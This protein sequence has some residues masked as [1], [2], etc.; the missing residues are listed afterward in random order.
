MTEQAKR[1]GHLTMSE[2][3]TRIYVFNGDADGLIAQYLLSIHLGKPNLRITGYKRD[4][5]LLK[6]L[7]LLAVSAASQLYVLD[8]SVK[9]N[10][11]YLLPLL[12]QGNV[13]V[14]WFDHHAPGD[15][16]VH[17]NLKLHINQAS[18]TCTAMIVNTFFGNR[19][20]LW[21]AMALFGDNNAETAEAILKNQEVSI[22][23]KSLLKKAGILLN[24]NAYAEK[25]GDALFEPADLAIRMDAFI[26]ESDSKAALKFARDQGI[27]APLET[28]YLQDEIRFQNLQPIQVSE[29]SQA[30]L[31]PNEPWARRFSATWV[32]ALVSAK[33]A[34]AL[35]ALAI[36]IE[37]EDKSFSV[38]IRS[39]SKSMGEI[40]SA[41]ELA[42]EF[43]SGGGRKLAA[44]INQ[45]EK[46]ALPK[47]LDRFQKFYAG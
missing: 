22:E 20:P 31:V 13:D 45:L 7:P 16:P 36:L 21:T 5:Q 11:E 17:K 15:V 35:V 39:P 27:F 28:Q 26:L 8:I 24:Y 25:P 42:S 18:T 30:Y 14:T 38:S 23:E 29:N 41:A 33:P 37:R 32:N 10:L 2:E 3:L 12:N 43:V 40:K 9:Q 4:N 1:D 34:A 6:K 47:F 46:S 44:G 19:H